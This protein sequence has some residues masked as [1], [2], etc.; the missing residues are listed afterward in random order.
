MADK[1]KNSA[2][3]S[4][5][6]TEDQ[7]FKFIGFEVFPGKPKDLF[8]NEA[9]KQKFVDAAQAKREKGDVI[10]EECTLLEERV[11][12]S[13]RLV[14]TI[15]SLIL[16]ASLFLPWYSAYNETVEETQ[17]KLS[18]VVSDSL[19][20][21]DSLAGSDS[22]TLADAEGVA[23][24]VVSAAPTDNVTPGQPVATE[25]EGE[26]PEVASEAVTPNE[27]IIHG[28]VAKKKVHKEYTRLSGFGSLVAIG[29]LGSYVFG[30][31]IATSGIAI[32]LILFMILCV[33][34]PGY[35][36]YGLYGAKGNADQQALKLKKILKLSWLPLF[37]FLGT[38]ILSFLGG[39][40]GF[41]P[42][43]YF[44]SLGTEFG[45]G[46]FFGTLSW[47]VFV[48]VAMS[49]LIAVKGVEI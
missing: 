35:T 24:S 39:S 20:I 18:E 37:L 28:Y 42:A 16:F 15:A 38:I 31:G 22:L 19:D 8:K 33:A 2:S 46:A 25:T 30:S 43:R 7:R 10:R 6:I 4:K 1:E 26:T 5:R 48:S 21:V 17:V 44:V 12:L 45:P 29:S 41:D 23:D 11:S 32:L 3:S 9:E 14:L 34:L 13:D 27:E 47:G 40:Y 49:I 36:L